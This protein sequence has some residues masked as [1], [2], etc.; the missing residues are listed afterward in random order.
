MDSI[1]NLFLLIASAIDW[2]KKIDPWLTI[3]IHSVAWI[4]GFIALRKICMKAYSKISAAVGGDVSVAAGLT[5]ATLSFLF[6]M[7]AIAFYSNGRPYLGTYTG[8]L[9]IIAVASYS[10]LMFVSRGKSPAPASGDSSG[11][12]ILLNERK[13]EI[14]FKDVSGMAA[15]KQDLMD[16]Y[17]DHQQ[18]S[19]GGKEAKNGVLLSGD[20]GNGKTFIA[21]AFA[22]ELGWNF[23]AFNIGDLASAWVGV[24]VSRVNAIF[25][26]AMKAENLVLFFDECDSMLSSRDSM[27]GGNAADEDNK[28]LVNAFLTGMTNI[29]RHKNVIAIAATNYR[30]KLDGA[31]V[32]EGRFDFKIE[33]PNPDAEARRGLLEKFSK[34]KEW[35][36]VI[37]EDVM[38]RL[39]RRWEGFSVSRIRSIAEKILK[40][41]KAQGRKEVSLEDAFLALRQVQ[42]SAGDQ[43]KEDTPTLKDGRLHF[44]PE[45]KAKLINLASRLENIDEVERLGGTVPKGAIFWGPPGTGKTAVAMSLARTSG[46][47]FLATTGSDLL[48]DNG[49]GIDGIIKKARDLRPCIVFIDEAEEALGDRSNSRYGSIVTNKLLAVTDG[50]KALHD[51]LFIAAT[52]HPDKLDQA[53]TRGGRFSE[54]FEFK[55]P[56]ENTVLLM[57]REWITS[58]KGTTPFHEEFTPEAVSQHLNGMAPSDI[59]E[60]L[61][62]AVN[63]GVGRIMSGEGEEAI[64]L[65]DLHAVL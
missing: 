58:K 21:E 64:I 40:A 3:A 37:P 30:D 28:N 60:A 2:T 47:A 46:W 11:G 44:D 8:I 49:T 61:Q 57:V 31:A 5:V 54:H 35:Q 59:K 65:K 34:D 25:A 14:A 17:R 20:P 15:M 63:T 12:L 38:K 55:K 1:Q 51:V 41:A 24:K 26:E 22:G 62:Q 45:M 53:I 27:M 29:R 4:A 43:V 23:S 10:D 36:P 19:K 48:A 52:N 7:G 50:T 56:E 18:S 42:G 39:V 32:R 6:L 16:A 33:I 13:P 9:F